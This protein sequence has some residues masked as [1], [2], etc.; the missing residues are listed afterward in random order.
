MTKTVA[1]AQDLL[2]D[3][4]QDGDVKEALSNFDHQLVEADTEEAKQL[5]A[6]YGITAFPT[7]II[8]SNDD[9]T[10]TISGF[11]NEKQQLN[12]L[13]SPDF[14]EVASH[15]GSQDSGLSDTAK[16]FICVFAKNESFEDFMIKTENMVKREGIKYKNIHKF[17]SDS[18]TDIICENK[19]IIYMRKKP[20][21]FKY[22]LDTLN[23][24]FIE[25]LIDHDKDGKCN[26]NVDYS[27]KEILEDGTEED[28]MEFLD[29]IIDAYNKGE[30]G[31]RVGHDI[32]TLKRV[33]AAL[34]FCLETR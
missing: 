11:L 5:M 28:L 33:R 30:K 6:K 15:M 20:S 21:L 10:Y 1:I 18:S 8:V 32:S 3:T 7:Q 22:A 29:K 9:E 24:E 13:E 2:N 16:K 19:K 14:V 27:Q 25:G 34:D 4:Y 26:P 23:Y 12:F 17:V 31:M